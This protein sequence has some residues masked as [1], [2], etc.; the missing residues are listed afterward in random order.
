M[1]KYLCLLLLL[2]LLVSISTT[3]FAEEPYYNSEFIFE[4]TFEEPIMHHAHASAIIVCPNGDLRVVWYENGPKLKDPR[5]FSKD[6]DKSA[7]VR[8]VGSRRAVG[9]S[10]WEKPF[11]M[12]DTFGVADNNPTLCIDADQRLWLVHTTMLAAPQWTW[13]GSILQF[14]ISS[15]Y[16]QPGPPKWESS[17]LLLPHPVGLEKNLEAVEKAMG[18]PAYFEKY[19]GNEERMKKFLAHAKENVQEIAKQRIG[20]MSRTHPII[21]KNGTLL[22]PLSNENFD[23]PMMAMTSDGGKTW[24]YS[25]P[26]PGVWMIQP[27]VVEL[28]DG[29]LH[30]YFRNGDSR[31]RIKRSVSTDAGMTWSFPELT[32][33]PH[34]GGG[35]E[36]LLLKSGNLALVYNNK[37]TKPRDKL[38]ISI[39]DD[40]GKTWKWT[41]Q[42]E[43]TPGGRF[44]YPSIVQTDDGTIHVSYSWELRTIK[45]VEF[46]EAW[47]KAGDA[48]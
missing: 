40:L 31:H 32:D 26:V 39:S 6:G 17:S 21:L 23:I 7:D 42:L 41:R 9:A 28:P 47:V 27:S 45:H 2:L 10:Q 12:N 14:K 5:F 33:R 19:G 43:E 24:N 11:V 36:V 30:A 8:I 34:P 25:N 22:L 3:T 13:P 20:W 4:P 48:K 37:E 18:T 38:A 1:K 44:D 16:D 35:V 29:T 15:D 46:N